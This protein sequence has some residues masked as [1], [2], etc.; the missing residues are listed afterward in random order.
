MSV[1]E[2]VGRASEEVLRIPA[3]VMNLLR[4]SYSTRETVLDWMLAAAVVAVCAYAV[5]PMLKRPR[6]DKT[7]MKPNQDVKEAV[8]GVDSIYKRT[9]TYN[10]PP[11]RRVAHRVGPS[12][13]SAP[14]PPIVGPISAGVQFCDGSQGLGAFWPPHEPPADDAGAE[15]TGVGYSHKLR[16]H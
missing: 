1:E 15:D 6:L 14:R 11:G 16:A 7:D 4:Q 10:L 3:G 13:F 5:W 8:G 12:P 9:Y 2:N